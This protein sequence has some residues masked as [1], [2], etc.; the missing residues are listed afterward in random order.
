MP[1][2]PDPIRV[3]VGTGGEASPTRDADA[4]LAGFAAPAP[5]ARPMMRWWWFGPDVSRSDIV[6]QLNAVADAGLGGV[7]VAYV[8]PLSRVEHPFLSAGFLDDLRFAADTAESLGLRFDVTLGSGWSFGGP[9]VTAETASRKLLWDVREI[10]GDSVRIGAHPRWPGEELVTAYVGEGSLQE[11]PASF[12]RLAIEAAPSDG[13]FALVPAGR[14]PRLVA[15]AWSVPTGQQVKRAAAGAEGPVLDHYS[16][17]AV[18]DHLKAVADPLVDAVGADRIGSVFCDSL[19]A[20]DADWTPTLPAEFR[21]RRSRDPLDE[22]W[23]LRFDAPGADRFRAEFYETL[24]DLFEENF[25]TQIREWAAERGVPFRVQNYGVPLTRLSSYRAVDIIEGEGWGWRG[26]TQT[27]W[28]ASAAHRLGRDI[29]SAEAWT[30]V[31]S[32]SLRATPLDLKGEAHEH[33]LL[34]VNHLIGHGWPASPASSGADLGRLF[35]ASGALDDRNAWWPAMPALAEYLTRLCWL[36]RQ[37]RPV[38][39][40]TLYLP[41]ADAYDMLGVAQGGTL[42]LWRTARDIIGDVIPGAI[43]DAG[44]D[45]DLV[46]DRM[47]ETLDPAA[48]AATGPV[49][50]PHVER[51]PEG[52]R[53][54]LRAVH[55]A[56]GTVIDVRREPAATDDSSTW[57]VTTDDALGGELR[58]TATPD[59]RIEPSCTDIGFVH[60]RVDDVDVYFVANTGVQGRRFSVSP[61][62]TGMRWQLWDP[63]T[64]LVTGEGDGP[65]VPLELAPYEARVLV[66]T[67][68]E[69]GSNS[70]TGNASRAGAVSR[71]EHPLGDE[72]RPWTVTFPGEGASPVALPHDWSEERPY[73]AGTA[74]YEHV[75][76]ATALWGDER[77]ARVELDFGEAAPV[78]TDEA[79]E[80]GM[81][82]ASFRAMVEPPVREIAVVAV[83]GV[84]CGTLY[85]PPY[86]LDV[87]G[88]LR[89][90]DNVLSVTVGNATAAAL[91]APDVVQA[92]EADV[93]AS[94][95][96]YGVRFR[97]QDVEH[98]ADGLRSGLLAV[99]TLRWEGSR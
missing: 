35:Y 38:A 86:R 29:V 12:E 24:S 66:L 40:V 82:G 64:G 43:R 59:L 94:H 75:F 72:A 44:F 14:T 67:G 70:A 8:Y 33:F 58:A 25:L 16:A 47:L 4:L 55:E 26:V 22:L 91:A 81:R 87:T 19:E 15:L 56:G 3:D 85:A 9:H 90:G 93:A 48:V 45:F 60:R 77:P 74:T 98:A 84:E 11:P 30:W 63:Q 21:E 68:T 32:P 53:G 1:V 95:E 17:T 69:A 2:P 88:A 6:R 65:V 79:A 76:D 18:R 80:R 27:R 96:R 83:N 46:D 78:R 54:W 73:F 49:V 10:G 5:G 41:S 51:L 61:R 31:H 7:E 52:T 92:L 71:G 28:A 37:G 20:Y 62:A 39:D 42:D 97:M 57:R 13:A 89:P 50:L 99:P 23:K 36:L 34:G